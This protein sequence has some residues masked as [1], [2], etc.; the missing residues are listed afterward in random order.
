MHLDWNPLRAR[1][2]DLNR[3]MRARTCD[4]GC[5]RKMRRSQNLQRQNRRAR[6]KIQFRAA[7][8]TTTRNQYPE[9]ELDFED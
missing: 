2:G 6:I 3:R 8:S 5:A 9:N 4:I 1:D 7:S